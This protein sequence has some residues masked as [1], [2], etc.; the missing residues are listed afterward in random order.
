MAQSRF[1]NVLV[2]N[3]Q[4]P[5]YPPCEPSIA[6]DPSN[7][8]RQVAGAVLNHV[9]YSADSGKTWTADVLRSRH[10]VFGDPCIT[11][12]NKGGFFYYHLSNP[13]GLGWAHPRLLDRIV[14][15]PLKSFEKRRWHR[16]A[17]IGMSHPKDQDKEWAHYDPVRQQHLVTWTQFDRY[18]SPLA[19]HQSNIYAAWSEDGRQWQPPVRINEVSGNCLDDSYTT[20]GATPC[21]NANGHWFV[22]W[23]HGGN[24]WFDRSTDGGKTWLE[25]DVK[26]VERG[27][28]WNFEIPGIGRANGMP[29]TA[30]DRSNGPHQGTIYINWADQREGDTDVWL[31]KSTDGGTTWTSPVRVNGDPPG[32]HQFFTWMAL[33]Q[34]TGYLYFVYYDRRHYTDTQTDVYLSVS[35]D[36]GKTFESERISESPFT[37]TPTVFFGDYNN[38]SA[39]NGVVRPIWT[40]CDNGRLSIW[41]A[42]IND[43]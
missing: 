7:A 20:E 38:I 9:F 1:Q 41:T 17:G 34:S 14:A 30:C 22:A 24:I 31:T 12:D 6:I 43:K 10:G 26:A 39:V 27:A 18:N 36:G 8:A 16:G 32:T 28:L 37:P 11:T 35:R 40:R 42:L 4:P 33:D 23:S 3:H 21:S 19:E 25:H 2:Y 15:Q 13:T 29:I 5:R